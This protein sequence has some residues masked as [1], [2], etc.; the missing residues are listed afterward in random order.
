MVQREAETFNGTLTWKWFGKPIAKLGNLSWFPSE[1]KYCLSFGV[2]NE[3]HQLN[4]LGV[5][6][7]EEEIFV[8]PFSNGELFGR[9]MWHNMKVLFESHFDPY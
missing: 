3:S 2:L 5:Q 4:G 7:F 9:G 1:M 8:G 6:L